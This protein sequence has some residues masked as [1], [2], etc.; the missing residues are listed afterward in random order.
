MGYDKSKWIVCSDRTSRILK[1]IKCS[2]VWESKQ[3]AYV[4]RECQQY[5]PIFTNQHLI[6]TF[7]P[8]IGT[9]IL[10]VLRNG[11]NVIRE[12]ISI[13]IRVEHAIIG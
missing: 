4:V 9:C 7:V 5:E 6:F 13:I 12:I 3:T 2:I 8:Y 11:F 10:V 1:Q